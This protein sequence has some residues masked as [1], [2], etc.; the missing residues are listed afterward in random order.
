MPF[1]QA[2]NLSID[3]DGDLALLK[4]DVPQRPVNVFTRAVMRDLDTALDRISA[5]GNLRVLVIRS[6]KKLGFVAGADIAQFADIKSEQEAVSLSAAGQQLFDKLELL[7]VASLAIIHGA[8]LGGGLEFALACDHRLVIDSPGTQLGLPEVELGLLPGWGGTQRLPRLVGLERALQIILGGKRLSA[9]EAVQWGLAD[10]IAHT[11]EEQRKLLPI[12]LDKVRA[13]GKRRLGRVPL[14][15][16]RQKF[17]ESSPLGRALLFRVARKQLERRLWD[18][19]PAPAEALNAVR[20]GLREGMQAG[21]AV[22]RAA[23]GRLALSPA[24]RNLVNV[25]LQREKAR[26]PAG[27]SGDPVKRIGIVGAGVMGA[28]IA[29]LAALRGCDV[30]VQEINEEALGAGILRIR[31]LFRKA[32]ERN[33][34]SSDEANRRLNAIRGTTTWEGFDGVEL[35]LE[36]VMEDAVI[37]RTVFHILDE[38]TRP[39]TVLASNTSSLLIANLEDKVTRPGRVA[40]LHFF[41][42]VHKMDLVEVVQGPQTDEATL[43]VLTRFALALGK[44]PLRVKDGPGF[45]VNRVLMPYLNEAVQLV[46]EGMDIDEIDAVMRRFGMPMSPLQVLDQ[47]GLDVAAHIAAAMQPHLGERYAPNPTFQRLSA[48]GWLGQKTGAGFYRYRGGKGVVNRDVLPLVRQE[49][50]PTAAALRVLSRDVRRQQARE[51]LVLLMV[52]EAAA[53]LGAGLVATPQELDLALILGTGWAPHRGGPLH[54]ADAYGVA[55]VVET[56]TDFAHRFGPHYEPCEELRRRAAE[57]RPFY[58]T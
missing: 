29:Q 7:P 2:E 44:T 58:P 52:N 46:A 38:R 27:M 4:L 22:E 42:P 55:R 36:A 56:L 17:L 45:A 50:P 37:K 40:G 26:K 18:D 33:I 53:L 24:C 54:Y 23:A 5:R 11:E 10:A 41:N 32:V 35:V 47:V 12:L 3:I 43:A 57:N 48:S 1:F 21:L 31:D 39:E 49:T 20:T 9:V 14:R 28:A 6:T 16:W 8:C 25:F 30:I 34:V 19:L 51:R 13:Q 15:T